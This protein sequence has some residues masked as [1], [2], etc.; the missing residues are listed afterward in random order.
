MNNNDKK[1]DTQTQGLESQLDSSRTLPRVLEKTW[2]SQIDVVPRQSLEPYDDGR[3]WFLI[4]RSE[5]WLGTVAQV[6][7]DNDVAQM[8]TWIEAQ[9]VSVYPSLQHIEGA[10]FQVIWFENA[11]VM[12]RYS[13][14]ESH[15]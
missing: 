6:V 3:L 10:V 8:K 14:G 4:T 9:Q 2:R 5:L 13:N 11:Y 15:E 1:I 7:M 12:A